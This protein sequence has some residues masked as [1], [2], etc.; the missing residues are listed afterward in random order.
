LFRV[1]VELLI[2]VQPETTGETAA[3]YSRVAPRYAEEGPP[4]FA[5]AGRRLVE[6]A[7]VQPGDVVLDLGTGRG[8]VLLSAARQVGPGG[9]AIGI[10]IASEMVTYTRRTLETEQL[11]QAS[12]QLMD[13]STLAFEARQ[14]TH[15]LSSFSVFFFEDL[16]AVLRKVHQLLRPNGVAGFAF[17]R[18]TDPRWR[19]YEQLLRDSGA[20]AGLPGARGYPRIRQPGVLGGLL[21]SAGFRDVVELEEPTDIWYASPE[22]WW[23]SLWTRGSRRPLERMSPELLE[24]VNTEA[25]LRARELADQQGV[26][27]RMQLVYVLAR[28]GEDDFP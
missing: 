5:H 15:V 14:F 1:V 12:V 28:R 22:A 19:W 16:P 13:V 10:D 26:L 18:S 23:A 27:E 24:R 25:L 2:V 21:E 4:Y 11:A 7:Q 9:R 20:L 6:V 17:S 8:A 3:F